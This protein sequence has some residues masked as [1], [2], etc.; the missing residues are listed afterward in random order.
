[1][2]LCR[3]A[4]VHLPPIAEQ[5]INFSD[6]DMQYRIEKVKFITPKDIDAAKSTRDWATLTSETEP[7]VGDLLVVILR[8]RC[9]RTPC[10][11]ANEFDFSRARMNNQLEET[12]AEYA[13]RHEGERWRLVWWPWEP[14]QD[15]KYEWVADCCG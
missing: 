2:A 11:S 10:P 9:M 8:V 12:C 15:A 1:M 14:P 5:M 3:N 4:Y 6:M 7:K 13:L